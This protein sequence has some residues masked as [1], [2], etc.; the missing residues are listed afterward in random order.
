[1]SA[2]PNTPGSS[3][4]PPSAKTKGG[5]GGKGGGKGKSG[6]GNQQQVDRMGVVGLVVDDV[7]C[8]WDEEVNVSCY[9]YCMMKGSSMLDSLF[10][11]MYVCVCAYLLCTSHHSFVCCTARVEST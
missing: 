1:M 8:M 7:Y 5:K 2:R 4:K 6:A 3:D 9:D 10:L 11:C